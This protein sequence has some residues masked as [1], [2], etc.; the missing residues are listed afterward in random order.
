MTQDEMK[1]GIRKACIEANP[2]G[3]IRTEC[4]NDGYHYRE[5]RLAD[6]LLAIKKVGYGSTD[7]WLGVLGHLADTWNLRA[8]D[9]ESQSPETIEFLNQLLNP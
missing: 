4:L 3:D 2:D 8:D 6:V 1:E 5:V 7:E 9:L